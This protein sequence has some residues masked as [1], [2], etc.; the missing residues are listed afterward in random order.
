MADDCRRVEQLLYVY[1]ERIDAGDFPGVGELFSHGHIVGPDGN[2]IARGA[3][4]VQ[5]LYETSTRLYECGTPCTQHMTTNAIIELDDSGLSAQGRARFTVFQCLPDFPLQPIISGR[6]ADRFSCID[7]QWGF[8]ERRMQ[9][10][11]AGDLSRHLLIELP[12]APNE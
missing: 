11:F 4:E 2:V 10:E 3:Q 6:Y 9:V 12:S 5:G 7:G 8:D 1:A